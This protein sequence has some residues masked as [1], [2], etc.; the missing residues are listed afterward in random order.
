MIM[1]SVLWRNQSTSIAA[2]IGPL[3]YRPDKKGSY[4]FGYA[5]VALCKSRGLIQ[6][7]VDVMASKADT[8]MSQSIRLFCLPKLRISSFRL[9]FLLLILLYD[10]TVVSRTAILYLRWCV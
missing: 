1:R 10:G 8:L 9:R 3:I 7:A 4:A 2:E 5:T 6:M